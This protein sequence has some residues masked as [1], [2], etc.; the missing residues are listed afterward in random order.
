MLQLND[1]DL[2]KLVSKCESEVN[3]LAE[4]HRSLI[5]NK[6]NCSIEDI[7]Q[8]ILLL[9]RDGYLGNEATNDGVNMYYMIFNPSDVSQAPCASLQDENVR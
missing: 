1:E 5:Q 7:R 3:T 6:I 9:H 8:R 2:L 4:I